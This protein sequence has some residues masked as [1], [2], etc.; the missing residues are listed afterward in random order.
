MVQYLQ[1]TLSKIFNWSSLLIDHPL[2]LIFAKRMKAIQTMYMPNSRNQSDD[3]LQYARHVG[4]QVVSYV[5]ASLQF[6]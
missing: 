4:C 1:N 2:F 6:Q 5:I 3:T